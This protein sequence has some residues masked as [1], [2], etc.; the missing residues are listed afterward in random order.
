MAT[1]RVLIQCF[2]YSLLLLTGFSCNTPADIS[3]LGYMIDPNNQT[4]HPEIRGIWQSIGNGYYLEAR[5]DS[6]LLYSYTTS[7]CYKELNDYL[8]GLLNSE[9]QFRLRDDTLGV[10]LTDYGADTEYL[11]SKKDFVRVASLPN[12]WI[13]Y[14]Q[15]KALPPVSQFN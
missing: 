12:G 10:Y 7:F 8:E 1:K 5:S 11:Q 4:V 15:M 3:P 13:S 6:L 9:S 2:A 14:A